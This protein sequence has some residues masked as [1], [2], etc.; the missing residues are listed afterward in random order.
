MTVPL[1]ETSAANVGIASRVIT[2]AFSVIAAI[3]LAT[4]AY[5]T[6]VCV[7]IIERLMTGAMF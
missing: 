5:I 4:P 7:H 3:V 1:R 6:V 2:P